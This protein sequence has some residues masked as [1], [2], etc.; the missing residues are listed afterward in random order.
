M[1]ASSLPPSLLNP[2]EVGDD[3]LIVPGV[4]Q[5]WQEV[6]LAMDRE[7]AMAGRRRGVDWPA[8]ASAGCAFLFALL[9][10]Y[11]ALGGTLGLWTIIQTGAQALVAVGLIQPAAVADWRAFYWH[12]FLW[13][14]WFLVW[15]LLLSL[16]VLQYQRRHERRGAPAA[17][18]SPG[19]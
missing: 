16:A 8:Y 2:A 6:G 1:I 18:I 7:R 19:A 15:G 4:V 3:P 10:L 17:G 11:W 14:P 12:L 13:S 5:P 9:N